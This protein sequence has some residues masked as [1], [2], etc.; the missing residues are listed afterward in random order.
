MAANRE[1]R[2]LWTG[3][4]VSAL[5]TMTTAVVLPLLA[6]T[7]FDAGPGWMGLLTA[8][9]W[10]P[11]LVVG[12]PAGAWVDRLDARRVMIAADL[13]AAL[14]VGSVPVAWLL[15]GLTLPQLVLAALASG[16]CAVFFRTAYGAFVP[17]VVRPEDLDVANGRLFGTEAA[18]QVA[19]PGLGGLLVRAVGGALAVAVD[20]VSYL[21]SALFLARMDPARLRPRADAPPRTALRREVADGVRVV[22]RDPF[23]RFF[24]AQGALSNF[25]LTGY[26]TLLVLFLV[27]DLGVGPGRVGLLLALGSAGGLVGSLVAARLAARSGNARALRWLQLLAGPAALLVP[28]AGP[29]AAAFLVPLGVA[30]VGVGVVGAN[31]VRSAFRQRYVPEHL[32][33]RTS[34]ASAVLVFG[35][36]PLAGLVAGGLGGTLGLRPTI[37]VMAALQLLT[38]LLVLVGPFRRGRDLPTGEATVAVPHEAPRSPA[39]RRR[40][41]PPPRRGRCVLS[42]AGGAAGG[43]ARRR[44]RRRSR[45]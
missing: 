20:T 13:A 45:R 6:V 27:R 5:G 7:A 18:M 42:R 3:E 10:L 8:A 39:T 1:F 14:A 31:V 32:L 2:L 41:L 38:S 12:L 29:G 26:Q 43:R 28:A 33:G 36:M 9:A 30:L 17:R 35:T 37:L 23:L 25:A 15:G 21:V 34:S 22:A 40:P 19:G 16:T 44:G 11:Y 4:G 24:A